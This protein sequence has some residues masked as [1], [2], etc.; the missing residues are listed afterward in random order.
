MHEHD[1]MLE[2]KSMPEEF[3]NVES[4]LQFFGKYGKIIN[5]WVCIAVFSRIWASSLWPAA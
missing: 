3:N 1:T 4:I 2:L 5:V